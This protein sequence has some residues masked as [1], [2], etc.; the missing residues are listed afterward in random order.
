VSQTDM[1]FRA[2]KGSVGRTEADKITSRGAATIVSPG[3]KS[4]G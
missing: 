2:G 3:R 1:H 4:W